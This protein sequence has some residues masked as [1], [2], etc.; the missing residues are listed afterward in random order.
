MDF[1]GR[2]WNYAKN[3]PLKTAGLVGGSVVAMAPAAIIVPVLLPFGFGAGGVIG[4][5]RQT[6]RDS[7][8]AR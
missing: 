2:G 7:V 3:N 1:L 8:R 5:K 4:G 6:R